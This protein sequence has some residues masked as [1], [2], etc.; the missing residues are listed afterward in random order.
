[1]LWLEIQE[2]KDRMKN[3]VFQNLGST[4][5]CLLHDMIVTKQLKV[6]DVVKCYYVC[7][8]G[9]YSKIRSQSKFMGREA[10]LFFI[11]NS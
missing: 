1:M 7:T 2:G 10:I 11:Q 9:I 4:T 8:G 6:I 3:K 5:A